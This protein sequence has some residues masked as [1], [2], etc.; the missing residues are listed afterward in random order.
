M[1]LKRWDSWPNRNVMSVYEMLGKERGIRTLVER[2]YTLMD[3]LPEA[4]TIRLM[5]PADLSQRQV[6]LVFDWAVWWS[7]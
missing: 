5:H 2:F 3:T 4:Q 7:Q 1:R 6:G